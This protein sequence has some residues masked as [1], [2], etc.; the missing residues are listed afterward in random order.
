VMLNGCD[1]Y[2]YIDDALNTA[3]QAVNPDDTTG[4]KYVDLVN[5]AMPAYFSALSNG[6]MAIVRGLMAHAEPKT[7]EQMFAT[8]ARDQIVLVSGE[9]DN[10]YTPGG[11]G[12][13]QPWDGLSE[14]GTLSR[15]VELAWETPTIA[16]GNYD[17]T[18]TG[19]GDADLYVRV[20]SA[21]NTT[22]YDC[23]P[24]KTGSNETCRVA[25]AQPAKVFVMV[26]G[27]AASSTF[28]LVG[29]VAP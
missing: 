17:F 22:D 15:N 11:G 3:H 24:Y 29:Q 25:L 9:Q 10:V 26:R 7:Y 1:T 16:A 28:D 14:S 4:F 21:P 13:P 20:G 6:T 23:R 2:A 12:D 19:T 18:L 5:N 8:V 27:Y